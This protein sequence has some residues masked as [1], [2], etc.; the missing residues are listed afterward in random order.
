MAKKKKKKTSEQTGANHANLLPKLNRAE[1][2]L[3]GVKKMIEERRY[4]P[5]IIQQVRAA[6]TALAA[7]EAAL[8]E[9][10]IRCC[11]QK[12]FEEGSP[13]DKNE[14][15]SEVVSLFKSALSKG[16]NL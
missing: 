8:I 14:K 10:H 13:E 5:D 4:C 9:S 16:V 7:I 11:V 1:G 2:Q 12:S 3:G 15:I 6:R